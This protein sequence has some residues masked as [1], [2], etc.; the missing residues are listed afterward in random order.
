MSEPTFLYILISTFASFIACFFSTLAGGGAGLILLPILLL[1]NIPFVNALACH[2]LAVGFIGVGSS[3]KFTKEKLI[4][5]KV[6]WWVSLVGLPFVVLGT[7]FSSELS[8]ETMK[9]IVGVVVLLIVLINLIKKNN[10]LIHNPQKLKGKDLY[11]VSF[12]L[13]LVAFYSGWISAASG[14]FTTMIFLYFLRYDQ[15]HATAMTLCAVGLFWNGIGALAHMLM[16]HILWYLAPGLVMGAVAGS[17]VGASIGIKKGNA[18]IRLFFLISAA[19]T[20]LLLI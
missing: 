5:W 11:F 4:D 10:S 14:V 17:Y 19:I 6:F 3:Y 16:G 18:F 7:I 20:G 9:P 13:I 1:L 15:L 8:G 12:L 2:K